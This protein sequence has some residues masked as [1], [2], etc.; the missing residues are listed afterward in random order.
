MSG[1]RNGCKL[2]WRRAAPR[3]RWTALLVLAAVLV[4]AAAASWCAL[5]PTS[6]PRTVSAS[7]GAAPPSARAA[8]EL[9]GTASTA[10]L[11]PPAPFAPAVSVGAAPSASGAPDAGRTLEK[12]LE[13]Y[14][15]AACLGILECFR[16]AG[17]IG[18]FAGQVRRFI[19]AD[20]KADPLRV[21]P[22][23]PAAALACMQA[24][25]RNRTIP[26]FDGPPG[27]LLCKYDY[28]VMLDGRITV[29]S[30]KGSYQPAPTATSASQEP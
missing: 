20:G 18:H 25:W 9:G 3:A 13:R 4:G 16:D 21:A 12:K 15:A 28:E 8:A 10:L 27:D 5:A 1:F 11:F 24:F 30:G 22:A 19:E 6:P 2:H 14:G 23:P 26:D 29:E 17:V 7:A